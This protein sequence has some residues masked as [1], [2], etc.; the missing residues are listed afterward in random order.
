MVRDSRGSAQL[1]AGVHGVR[2][3]LIVGDHAQ[4]WALGIKYG[5]KGSQ[6]QGNPTPMCGFTGLFP[7]VTSD[8]D[9]R[10]SSTQWRRSPMVPRTHQKNCQNTTLS[11]F[12][13]QNTETKTNH[14]PIPL[15]FNEMTSKSSQ[16]TNT[17]GAPP[18][19]PAQTSPPAAP[20]RTRPLQQHLRAWLPGSKTFVR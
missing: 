20:P 2:A 3:I 10:T 4:R 17:R 19:R 16:N 1:C 9:R 8:K 5:H 15:Y 13:L 14:S 11:Q 18:S 7:S 12:S 6:S